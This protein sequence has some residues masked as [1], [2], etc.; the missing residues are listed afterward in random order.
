MINAR[1]HW[2]LE[3]GGLTPTKIA[4]HPLVMSARSH[5]GGRVEEA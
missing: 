1:L 2:L 4:E 5:S 3:K